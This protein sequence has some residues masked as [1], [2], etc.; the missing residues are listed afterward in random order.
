VC[1]LHAR[2]FLGSAGLQRCRGELSFRSERKFVA[3][4]CRNQHARGVRSPE[5]P[6]ESAGASDFAWV[7][8]AC[9]VLFRSGVERQFFGVHLATRNGPKARFQYLITYVS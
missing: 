6:R 5:I 4:E 7:A 1:L 8:D 2:D 3:A 9:R